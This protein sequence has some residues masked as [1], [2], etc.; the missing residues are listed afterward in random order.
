MDRDSYAAHWL[1][2]GHALLALVFLL[3][4]LMLYKKL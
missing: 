3:L 4:G 1:S 2:A